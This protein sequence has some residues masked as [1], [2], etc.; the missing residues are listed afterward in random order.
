[1]STNEARVI[2]LSESEPVSFAEN[3][4]YQPILNGEAGDYPIYTGIQTAEPGYETPP[5]QHP[6][7]EVLHI[8]DGSAEAW[9]VGKEDEK[10]RLNAGDT[11]A[12]P[13]DQPH[14]FRVA[15]DTTLRLLGT[16]ISPQRIVKFDDGSESVMGT[17]EE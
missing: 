6:Y 2:R 1:M 17:A 5:H 14:V 15:G 9:L 4:Y 7:L 10:V 13:P 16:H 8:L 12:L 11:I 3:S